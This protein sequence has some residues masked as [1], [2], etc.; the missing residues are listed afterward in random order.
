[1]SVYHPKRV[2]KKIDKSYIVWFEESNSW[3]QF[4]EPSWFIYKLY[5]S[6]PDTV[7]ISLKFSK[8]YGLNLEESTHFVKDITTEIKNLSSHSYKQPVSLNVSLIEPPI[9]FFSCHTYCF[10]QK[11]FEIS[12]GTSLLEYMIHPQ[13]AHHE[14]KTKKKPDFRLETYSSGSSSILKSFDKAWIEDDPNHLKRKLFNE[15][16]SLMYGKADSDWLTF[17]HGSAV[18]NGKETIILSTSRGSGKSTL[19]AL[20][21]NRGS[22]FVSD[23]FVPID[24]RYCKAYPFPAAL[25]VKNGSYPVL[26]PYYS[27]LLDAEVLHF[28]ESDKTVRYLTLSSEYD[29]FKPLPV[30]SVVFIKYNPSISFSF[31]KVPVLEA[32]RGFNKEAW[33]ST[34]PSNAKKFINWFPRIPCYELEYSDNEPA[35][36]KLTELLDFKQG[37]ISFR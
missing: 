19:A 30:K 31:R 16:A 27:Q 14:V 21:C 33:I 24:K 20:L 4:E 35:I 8:K 28:R 10:N 37:G 1:M 18:S 22:K 34:N 13:F 11:I 2:S 6:V 12:F 7:S 29:F 15:I 9:S 32:I 23:D 5:N 17:I 26:L 3:I 36:K 25:S